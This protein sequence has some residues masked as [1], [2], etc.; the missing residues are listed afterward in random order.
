MRVRPGFLLRGARPGLADSTRL[1]EPCWPDLVVSPTDNR[2]QVH[3]ADVQ[4]M[5]PRN[6]MASSFQIPIDF[7]YLPVNT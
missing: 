7:I 1:V 2:I 6:L 4:D 3:V 5:A